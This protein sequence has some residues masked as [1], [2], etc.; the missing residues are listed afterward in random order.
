M[1]ERIAR[2]GSA[3]AARCRPVAV[4]AALAVAAGSAL[5]AGP[6][7][8]AVSPASVSTASAGGASGELGSISC[9]SAGNCTAVGELAPTSPKALFTVSEKHGVW[10]TAQ[11]VPGL[12]ALLGR[13]PVEARFAALSCSSAG[14]CGAAGFYSPSAKVTRAFVVSEKNGTWGKVKQLPDPAGAVSS[15]AQI[16]SLSC[17][18][19]GNCG[20]GGSYTPNGKVTFHNTG[21][22]VASEKNG[23]WGKARAVPGLAKLNTIHQAGVTQLTC[24]SAGNCLAAGTYAG[25]QGAEVFTVTENHGTWGSART[26]PRLIALATAGD[27]GFT[28]LSCKS[29]GNCTVVGFYYFISDQDVVFAFSEKNGVWARSRRSLAS[30]RCSRA[31]SARSTSAR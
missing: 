25:A 16:E 2:A 14:N 26:F 18:S 5:A 13:K 20:A 9:A 31:V 28:S 23:V 8:A 24:T 29:P 21:A 15:F 4:A 27:S 7:A 17:S 11:A 30:P 19:A 6:A 12:A 22:F 10:G 3:L 1:H